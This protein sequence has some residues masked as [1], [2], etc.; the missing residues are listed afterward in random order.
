MGS[1]TQLQKSVVI[2]S[3]L[4]DGYLRIFPKRK[5]ALLETNHSYK[6]KEYVDWKYSVLRNV[7]KSAPKIRRGNGGR[8]AYRFYTK[9]LAELTEFYKQFYRDGKKIIPE[10]L[11]IDPII[12][13]VWFMDDGSR[14]RDC[15]V[16]LNTQQFGIEDQK[17]LIHLLC[18]AGL[19]TAFNKDKTYYRLR[20]LKSSLPKLRALLKDTVI[21]SMQYK[22]SY[23]PVET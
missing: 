7:C 5:N 4:G 2:G 23:N 17:K 1:L 9:Q 14:C 12:L 6:Q 8:V 3:L 19:E 10:N 18:A 16:Y 13:S 20:F 11:T 22:L 21:S 15:D